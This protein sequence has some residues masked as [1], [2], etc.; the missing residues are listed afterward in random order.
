MSALVLLVSASGRPDHRPDHRRAGVGA[1]LLAG[2]LAVNAPWLVAGLLHAG[3][4]TSVGGADVFALHGEGTLP[5]PLAAL[6]LGGIWNIEV[7]PA[8]RHGALAW[9][10]LVLVIAIAAL[11]ARPWWRRD[12]DVRLVALWVVGYGLAVLTWVSPAFVDWC[13]AH[14]P[15]SGLL[16]DGARSLALCAPLLVSVVA[17]G[18]EAL[19]A[20]PTAVLPRVGLAVACVVLPVAVMADAAW[21]VRG[22]LAPA[23]YPPS[24]AE[25]R[26]ALSGA[27]GDVLVLPFSSYRA[28]AW[29]AHHKVLDP[30]GRYLPPNYVVNDELVVGSTKVA[31]EDPRVPRVIDALQLPAAEERAAALGAL[32]IGYVVRDTEAPGAGDPALDP[33]VAGRTLLEGSGVA[34][35]QL[36]ADVQARTA[37]PS[38]RGGMSLAWAAFA[39]VLLVGLVRLAKRVVAE[40]LVHQRSDARVRG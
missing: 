2:C 9:V 30:L 10:A 35:V 15:G 3:D 22:A 14:V 28:P 13:S 1:R 21:G 34:V 32:G 7:V 16:R 31:G 26:H 40:L 27:S 18:V 24:Y 4:A 8:S 36:V 6:G 33:P 37:T 23:H 20:R 39:G 11:G 19:V 29:N 17:S 5:A 38:A 12:G 25:A